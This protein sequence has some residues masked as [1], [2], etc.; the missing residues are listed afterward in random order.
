[1]SLLYAATARLPTANAHGLQIVENCAA[2]AAAG[3]EVTLLLARRRREP[4]LRAAA[5]PRDH[6]GVPH[7]FAIASAPCL[8]LLW[9]SRFLQPTAF[10]VMAATFGVGLVAAIRR[11]G[12]ATVVYSR[13]PLPLL[14]ASLAV[15]PR[16]LVYEAHQLPR[17]RQGRWLHAACVR[18]VGLVVAITS[19]IAAAAKACG[20]AAT[21]IARDG[22]R[23]DRFARAPEQDAARRS[24]GLSP[25]AFVVGYVGQLHTMGMAKGVEQLVDATAR[26]HDVPI[27][28]AV[29]GGPDAQAEALRRRWHALGLPG[30]RLVTTGQVPPERVP[31][32]LAALDVGTIPF[33]F[34]HHFA[35]CASPMKLFEYLA[36]GLPIVASDLPAI[37]EVL[38][39]G[40]TALL[41]PA[42][43]V[44]ALAV[45]LRRLWDDPGLRAT[46]AAGAR[47]AAGAY[48]WAARAERILGAIQAMKV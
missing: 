10:R 21:L 7:G 3:A 2:F 41:T 17:S 43:D 26:L 16:R 46:L 11:R 47:R 20:A 42:A 12:P 36:A 44:E 31:V 6:Y 40:E 37:T 34:T 25:D 32:W 29:V 24:L 13:D 4:G 9:S 14:F 38:V 1:M 8:D 30:E 35:E 27:T 15:P 18:R 45:S 39:D 19:R 23:A 28:L 22:F 33:P 5:D 48:T